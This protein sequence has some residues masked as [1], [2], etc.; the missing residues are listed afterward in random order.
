MIQAESQHTMLSFKQCT[1]QN[2]SKSGPV[3]GFPYKVPQILL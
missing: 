1:S 2:S 3:V